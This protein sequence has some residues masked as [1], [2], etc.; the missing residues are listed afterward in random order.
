MDRNQVMTDPKKL[1]KIEL[2]NHGIDIDKAKIPHRVYLLADSLYDEM[3]SRNVGEYKYPLGGKLFV[4]KDNENIG[5][6]KSMMCSPGIAIQAEDLAAGGVKELIHLGFAGGIGSNVKIGQVIL[7]EGAFNDTAVAGLYGYDE[8]IIYSDKI[9]SQEIKDLLVYKGLDFLQGL[10]W[11]TDA[12]YHETWGNILDYRE[13]NALCVEMEGVGLF[14]IAK[15][16]NIKATAVYVISDVFND[17]G[18][19]LGW[20][21]SKINSTVS[22]LI[23]A[24]IKSI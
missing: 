8:K 10:H 24:I 6:V 21:E 1:V 13:K 4:F 14:T 23:T 19:N 3:L 17:E 20:S 18:W 11:T 7:T 2:M 12:G 9:L 15:Y 16:R 5:F 22:E